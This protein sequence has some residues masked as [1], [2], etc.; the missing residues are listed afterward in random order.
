MVQ[1][2]LATVYEGLQRGGTFPARLLVKLAWLHLDWG[3]KLTYVL[4]LRACFGERNPR[5]G[6]HTIG[7]MYG[8]GI[9]VD[10]HCRVLHDDGH[11]YNSVLLT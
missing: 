4:T 11:G 9:H 3:D 8:L 2:P 5:T 6:A 1:H 7:T 10:F